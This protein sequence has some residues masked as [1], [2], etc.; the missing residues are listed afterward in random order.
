MGYFYLGVAL[1]TSKMK[2]FC[3]KKI[4][5]LTSNTENYFFISAVRM[6]FCVLF[7]FIFALAITGNINSFGID[8]ITLII[9][10][11]SG[12]S[13]ATFV[14]T[15]LLAIRT[16]AFAMLDVFL[17]LGII[18]PLLLCSIFFGE[19]IVWL[20][21]IGIIL[22]IIAV[23]IMCLYSSSIKGK[24]TF[25]GMVF[26]LICGFAN[27][28]SH[29][30]EKWFSYQMQHHLSSG[31]S[32]IDTAGFNVYTYLFATLILITCYILARTFKTKKEKSSYTASMDNAVLRRALNLVVIMA[33]C[34]FLHSYFCTLAANRLPSSE[35]YPLQQ[36]LSL[37]LSVA[38]SRILFKEKITA[39]CIV[40][41]ILTFIALLI[42]NVLPLAL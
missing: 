10:L 11:I 6:L 23:Y 5:G 22:L 9:S 41:V 1:I 35:L 19:K 28:L 30:T 12:I 15:W 7:G 32:V 38:M 42:I 13:S 16:S 2:A 25:K 4:S 36:G 21:W 17:T 34:L 8:G 18:V 29:F 40:G 26:L 14:I 24:I 37:I 3:S 20:K 27:G 39:K 31:E 33:I